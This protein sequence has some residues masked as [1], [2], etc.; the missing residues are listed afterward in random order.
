M[1]DSDLRVMTVNLSFLHTFKVSREQTANKFLYRLGNEQWNIPRLRALLEEVL[2]KDQTVTNY[3]IEHDFEHIGH[4]TMV[5]NARKLFQPTGREP[6]ILLAIED[7]TQHRLA[8]AALIKSEKL[9]ASGRLAAALAHEINNPL[10]AVTNLMALLGQS[11]ELVPQDRE[12]A[13]M[14]AMEL[15]RVIHL[16]QQSLGF[17]RA[18]GL[19]SLVNV[20]DVVESVFTLYAGQ[21]GKKR[22][23]LTKQFRFE[24][25]LQSYPADIRQV[26][27]TM[28]V[29]AMEA[30]GN[31]GR[32]VLR[33]SRSR[34]WRD[35]PDM[36]GVRITLA[37]NGVGISS[38]SLTRIFEPF[39]TTKG[40]KGTGLGLWVARG[41]I[42]RIGGSIHVRSRTTPGQ[43]GTCFSIFLPVQSANANP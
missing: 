7:V 31:G 4:R 24:G 39:F 12:Y 19:P 35:K 23:D 30:C 33:T 25:T 38:A 21:I 3:E 6:M 40:E 8:E 28:L 10:Q 26:L 5:L 16:V 37:D 42:D 29:N 36:K 1:L 18:E 2:P 41:I 13:T 27:S 14:A 17:Y 20:T 34:D 22:I 9:A 15:R 43:S 32:I 11:Q